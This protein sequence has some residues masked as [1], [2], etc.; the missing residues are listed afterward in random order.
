MISNDIKMNF[1]SLKIKIFKT[2]K[3]NTDKF[4]LFYFASIILCYFIA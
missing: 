2:A 1:I 3:I 4:P